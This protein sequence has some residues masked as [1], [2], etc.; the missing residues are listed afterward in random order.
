M[1]IW[2][3][4]LASGHFLFKAGAEGWD[5]APILELP[6]FWTRLLRQA[7][8]VALVLIVM[9]ALNRNIRYSVWRWWH[10]LSG[11]LFLVGVLHWLRFRSPLRPE[12]APGAGLAE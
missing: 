7:S 11:P 2:A 4:V 12:S 6:A 3:L 1:G 5:V 8:Y 10:K 9:L